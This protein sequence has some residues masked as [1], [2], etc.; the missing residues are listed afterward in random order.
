MSIFKTR[1]AKEGKLKTEP[2]DSDSV[3]KVNGQFGR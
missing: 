2:M 1:T 3:L